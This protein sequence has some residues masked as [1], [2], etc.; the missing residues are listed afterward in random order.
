MINVH[1]VPHTH[2]DVGWIITVDQYYYKQVQ[3]ILDGVIAELKADPSKR[4]IYV[5]QAFFTRWYDEQDED[6][7]HDVTKLVNEGRLEFILGGWSMTD[8]ASTHYS[9]II[10][11]HKI[12]FEFLR[13][14]FGECG[15]PRI[16]WQI[17]PFGHSRE[18]ASLFAQFGFD[19]LF[20]GRL[21]YQDKAKRE[22]TKTM[23]FVWEASPKN[24]G[25]KANL[26]T[27]VLPN[28]Y[29][30]PKDF[31]FDVSCFNFN[32]MIKDNPKLHDYNIDE[33]VDKFINEVNNQAKHYR[34]KHLIMTMGSDFN[35]V[36]A[37]MFFKEMDKLIKYVNA[38]QSK[39][40][41]I[42]LLYSTPSCY[43]KELNN[44][45]LQWTTKQDDFFPYAD[46]P[47]TFWTGYFTSRPA[48]KFFARK[49]NNYYQSMKQ[50][51][52]FAGAAQ[53]KTIHAQLHHIGSVVGIAQ[54]HDAISGTSTQAVAFDYA[55]R[56]SEGITSGK[57]VLQNFYD[58][59]MPKVRGNPAPE[60]VVCDNLNSSVCSVT[61]SNSKRFQVTL[62][63]PLARPVQYLTRLP[64][65]KGV[66]TVVS[67]EGPIQSDIFPASD[68]TKSL[69][70]GASQQADSELVF[71]ASVPAAG[72]ITYFVEKSSNKGFASKEAEQSQDTVIR[73]KYV[74]VK[75]D[76]QG[77]MSAMSN[78]AMNIE[79]PLHQNFLYYPAFQGSCTSDSNKQPSGA[80]IFRPK[81]QS[82]VQLKISKWEGVHKG[83]IVQEA[84]QK[85]GDWASQVVRVYQDKPY[86]EVE[87]TV[88]PIPI[89]D[90]VGKEFMTRYNIPN[91]GSN[92]VFYTD[93]NGREILQRKLNYR[94]T[95]TLNQTE[96]VAGNFYPVNALIGIKSDKS[97]LQFTVLTDRSHSGTSL[98]DGDV[99]IMLHRRLLDDDCKGVGEALNET[100][101]GHGLIVRGKH[102]LLL[103]NVS[104]AARQYR[105]L[106]HEVFLQ[107]QATFS[108]EQ[109]SPANYF[110]KFNGNF[111]GLYTQF[112]PNL[113]LLTLEGVQGAPVVPA[114]PGTVPYLLRLEHFYEKDEDNSLSKPLTFDLKKLLYPYGLNSVHEL[115]LG[116][117]ILASDLHRLYWKTENNKK[118][119]Q[120]HP[121]RVQ[122]TEITLG[123]MEIIT[124][125][126]DIFTG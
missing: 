37:H 52:A 39:G 45:D 22:E 9:A 81:D 71:I 90:G 115:A 51:A 55:Q 108:S 89:N 70:P 121:L 113:H 67:S 102:Y 125:Q 42:N 3:W 85:F 80:Y 15:R 78:L 1:L 110:D 54:H 76:S 111:S 79:I 56:L 104:T 20:F 48:L 44:D 92:G 118:G 11:N 19:G 25:G 46:R 74:S 117:N 100:A 35:Y 30:P 47:H 27:G 86:V 50:M 84:R 105:P 33:M 93:A 64:V 12:G 91:F 106:A 60:Q 122:G 18:Q 101:Y 112:P 96:P 77:Q 97:N 69:I 43:V 114:V 109:S 124:L 21:D 28:G 5:E 99:E 65:K 10:D 58:F 95:W 98:N 72:Y 41:K 8:E 107:P 82:H 23:E 120:S 26:F 88:G 38:R 36:Q 14:T 75:F 29:N 40:S 2:D 61:V 17:D 7:Q 31:C 62:Y 24:L 73:G 116:A 16:G 6:T 94:P 57:V 83:K 87:Y 63:N 119:D 32:P 49:V 123:P 103:S 13:Q 53:N 68:V 34:T 66:Y 4:F 59:E 126:I